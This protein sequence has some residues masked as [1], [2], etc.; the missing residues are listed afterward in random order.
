M[1]KTKADRLGDYFNPASPDNPIDSH[2]RKIFLEAVRQE[3]PSVLE[4]LQKEVFP[5]YQSIVQPEGYTLARATDLAT[6]GTSVAAPRRALVVPLVAAEYLH[7]YSDLNEA[8]AKWKRT[9][10]LDVPWMIEKALLTLHYWKTDRAREALKWSPVWPI[11]EML[12]TGAEAAM[13]EFVPL[14]KQAWE[15]EEE[16][17]D[18]YFRRLDNEYAKAKAAYRTRIIGLCQQKGWRITH[19]RDDDEHFTWLARFQCGEEPLEKLAKCHGKEKTA[20][21]RGIQ[22]AAKLIALPLR[23]KLPRRDSRVG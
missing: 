19:K 5:I 11:R 3:V 9:Y 18:Q 15:P 12:L 7:R 21:W 1:R 6:L 16:T 20:C 8:L 17:L 23:D 14:I 2:Y 4:G 13:A 22:G 10:H